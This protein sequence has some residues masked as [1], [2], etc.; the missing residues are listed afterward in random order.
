MTPLENLTG[1]EL[2]VRRVL[3]EQPEA[4]LRELD[5]RALHGWRP[6][7]GARARSV[8]RRPAAVPDRRVA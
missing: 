6:T 3:G 5:R 8:L 7:P 4:I 1:E 2:L